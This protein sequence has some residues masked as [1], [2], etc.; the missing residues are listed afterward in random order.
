MNEI[1]RRGSLGS[2]TAR[3]SICKGS[4]EKPPVEVGAGD[5]LHDQVLKSPGVAGAVEPCVIKRDEAGM[6]ES[7]KQAHFGPPPL[8]VRGIRYIAAEEFHG[9]IP[10]QHFVTGAVNSGHA[11]AAQ[12]LKQSVPACQGLCES[13][14]WIHVLC[15]AAGAGKKP[16]R[17]AGGQRWA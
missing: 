6:A 2:Q 3:V 13:S 8:Q 5:I 4:G 11:A 9:H 16:L 1:Q 15:V 12:E 7:C 14:V 10:A 17:L